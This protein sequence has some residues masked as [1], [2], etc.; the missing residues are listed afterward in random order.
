MRVPEMEIPADK[1]LEFLHRLA[2]MPKDW[3][4]DKYVYDE[5][6]WLEFSGFGD[7]KNYL[8]SKYYAATDAMFD[9]CVGLAKTP[10]ENSEYEYTI[11]GE[12]FHALLAALYAESWGLD[13]DFG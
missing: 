8:N 12:V 3:K 9:I 5:D 6:L 13:I 1:V 4:S 7:N 10:P 2:H 11:E